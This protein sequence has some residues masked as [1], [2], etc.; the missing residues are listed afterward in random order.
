MHHTFNIL[1]TKLIRACMCLCV[2]RCFCSS[3]K[4]ARCLS[5]GSAVWAATW[6]TPSFTCKTPCRTAEPSPSSCWQTHSRDDR[7]CRWDRSPSKHIYRG[8]GKYQ[9]FIH[10]FCS[11]LLPLKSTQYWCCILVYTWLVL[12][13]YNVKNQNK[14]NAREHRNKARCSL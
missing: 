7:P 1:N 14:I 10:S 8:K 9:A 3:V 12:V 4:P 6:A 11:L 2:P 13:L 5:A